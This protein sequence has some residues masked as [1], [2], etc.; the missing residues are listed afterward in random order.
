L[1]K[2]HAKFEAKYRVL[3]NP[4]KAQYGKSLENPKDEHKK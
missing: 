1:K 3:T 4:N 2:L